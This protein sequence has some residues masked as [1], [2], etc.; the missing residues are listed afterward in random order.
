MQ[1]RGVW[2]KPR[3]FRGKTRAVG[4]ENEIPSVVM[5]RLDHIETDAKA[6]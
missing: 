2:L 4:A 5:K 6:F 3:Q 1:M